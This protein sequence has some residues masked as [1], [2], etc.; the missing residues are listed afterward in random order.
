MAAVQT[1]TV[2]IAAGESLSSSANLTNYGVGLIMAPP[3]WTPANLSFQISV[4]NVVF[5]D[6][7]SREGV[8]IVRAIRAGTAALM[9]PTL[10]QSALYLK[11][12]SGPRSNP[13]NQEEDRTI[14][15][16]LI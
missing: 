3:A 9:D 13:V 7:F 14:T 16:G 5:A 8:E 15:L 12:R 4:D 11:V 2:T 1:A 6:L 10:T